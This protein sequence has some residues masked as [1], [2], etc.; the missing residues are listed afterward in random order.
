MKKAI[1][2]LHGFKRNDVNDF[3]EVD[4]YINTFEAD[5]IYTEI[6]F[7]NY[8]KK[9]LNLKHFDKRVNE[10]AEMIN[11]DNPEELIIIGYSTGNIFASLVLDKLNIKNVKY[12]GIVPPFKAHI[13]KWKE[14]LNKMKQVEKDLM[15]KLGK[16]RYERLKKAKQD[17]QVAEKYPVKIIFFMFRKVI[18][19]RK[20]SLMNM[21]NAHF[22]IAED[23]HIVKTNVSID[24]LSK[25]GTND[26]TIKPFTHDL[27]LR[28]EKQIFIDWMESVSK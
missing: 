11:N 5:K 27:I 19:K 3:E 12:F 26:L 10:V 7:N 4:D 17:S 15:K 8:D 25:N 1:L 2:L 20:H 9:T 6:W 23:D 21:K 16:E 22:L 14:T 13:L 24:V 28:K 18:R